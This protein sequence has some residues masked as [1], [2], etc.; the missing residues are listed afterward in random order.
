MKDGS[1]D[2]IFC[3]FHF[4]RV[5]SIQLILKKNEDLCSFFTFFILIVKN[6]QEEK[7]QD[8]ENLEKI[9][10]DTV[11]QN[12][13]IIYKIVHLYASLPSDKADLEQEIFLQLWKAFPSFRSEAKFETWMYRV[14]LNTAIL[15][16]KKW[17]KPFLILKKARSYDPIFNY[18]E[19]DQHDQNFKMMLKCIDKLNDLE[20]A[21]LHLYF[22][23]KNYEEIGQILGLST[24][25][26][27]V[28][29]FRIREKLK[30][31]LE[32]SLREESCYQMKF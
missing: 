12:I 2:I 3:N 5:F 31:D 22:E 15:C 11:Y 19:P 9:F 16:Q 7:M 4:I 29:M 25:N 24:K 8:K 13:R 21:I 10:I 17:K 18:N 28:K 26:I 14:A 23:N 32:I 20:K 30:K 1:L 27:N 6:Q